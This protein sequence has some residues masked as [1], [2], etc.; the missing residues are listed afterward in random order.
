LQTGDMGE[1]TIHTTP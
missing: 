1:F